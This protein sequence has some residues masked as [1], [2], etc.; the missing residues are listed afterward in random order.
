MKRYLSVVLVLAVMVG[1][2]GCGKKNRDNAMSEAL[3]QASSGLEGTAEQGNFV[4][5]SDD[6]TTTAANPAAPAVAGAPVAPPSQVEAPAVVGDKPTDQQIQQ[7]LQGAGLYN[8]PIDGKIGPGTKKAIRKF[9]I[10]NELTVDGKVGKKTWAKLAPHL[11]NAAA[12]AAPAAVQEAVP[13][14]PSVPATKGS[15]ENAY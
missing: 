11:S 4:V 2:S 1:V 14:A 9:Q 12:S 13:A 3:Q 8:G 7:A 15:T 10:Q 6:A 5:Y